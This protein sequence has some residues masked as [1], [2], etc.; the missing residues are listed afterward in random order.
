MSLFM[1]VDLYTHSQVSSRFKINGIIV[2]VG[3]I[4]WREKS[5]LVFQVSVDSPNMRNYTKFVCLLAMF[6]KST[7]VSSSA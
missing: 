3:E 4:E 6:F 7:L 2:I 1:K 5:F